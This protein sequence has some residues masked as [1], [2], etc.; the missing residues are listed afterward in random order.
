[1]TN[2]LLNPRIA[3]IRRYRRRQS[4][5]PAFSWIVIAVHLTILPSAAL[6]AT[7]VP[8]LSFNQIVDHAELIVEGTV[9]D[10]ESSWS[11]DRSTIYTYVTLGRISQI[12][13]NVDG[14]RLTLRFQGGTVGEY[15]LAVPGIPTFS[16]GERTILFVRDNGYAVSSI[17]G[18][19]QGR[20]RV[21]DDL[22]LDHAGLELAGFRNGRLIKVL[23]SEHAISAAEGDSGIS[24]GVEADDQIPVHLPLPSAGATSATT[25]S[26]Y[27][28]QGSEESRP[29]EVVSRGQESDST[30]GAVSAPDVSPPGV[31]LLLSP[32]AAPIFLG[33]EE[34]DGTRIFRQ[35]FIRAIQAR[36]GRKTE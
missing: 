11:D 1:V 15:T 4:S 19:F 23:P 21:V 26:E 2:K 27:D 18:F 14:S 9:E 17:V 8:A 20:F 32:E 12:H 10:I 3:L 31:A 36:L 25:D 35:D 24:A 22:V 6:H 34:D 13:G 29:P 30:S 28:R 5:L 7:T 16:P 33:A